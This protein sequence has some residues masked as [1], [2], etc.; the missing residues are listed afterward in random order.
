[1]VKFEAE[2]QKRQRGSWK[3]GSKLEGLMEC[4]KLPQRGGAPTADIPRHRQPRNAS[5]G[6][7]CCLLPVSRFNSVEPLDAIGG[8][9]RFCGTPVEKHWSTVSSIHIEALFLFQKISATIQCFNSA[10]LA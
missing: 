7:K 2:G 8:T 9:L 5:S 10:L 6:C 4:C 1:M 3:G